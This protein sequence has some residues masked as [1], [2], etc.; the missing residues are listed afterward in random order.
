M[1]VTQN[2][3]N[4]FA[5]TSI[6]LIFEFQHKIYRLSVSNDKSD[7]FYSSYIKIIE[8]I[9]KMENFQKIKNKKF[10]QYNEKS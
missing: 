10:L 4:V 6:N 5:K 7:L 2:D 9:E 3:A 8:I 1:F